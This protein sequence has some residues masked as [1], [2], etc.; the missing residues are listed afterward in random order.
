M[1]FQSTATPPQFLGLASGVHSSC[2]GSARAH[3]EASGGESRQATIRAP[4]RD[5]GAGV[6]MG[7]RGVRIPAIFAA[8]P[9][10]STRGMEFGDAGAEPAADGEDGGGRSGGL[11]RGKR[12]KA[13]LGAAFGAAKAMRT[14]QRRIST[15]SQPGSRAAARENPIP[16]PRQL[17]AGFLWDGLLAPILST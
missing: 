4:E 9:Q 13:P 10:E 8:R 11:S 16:P 14:G 6:R 7:E 15:A 1:L 5:G 12:E 3:G 17:R 2:P